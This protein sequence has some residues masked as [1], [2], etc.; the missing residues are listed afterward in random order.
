MHRGASGEEVNSRSR[1][2]PMKRRH[3]GWATATEATRFGAARVRH[4]A[5][6]VKAT[7]IKR[8]EAVR[9][10]GWKAGAVTMPFCFAFYHIHWIVYC[11]PFMMTTEMTLLNFFFLGKSPHFF[12]AIAWSILLYQLDANHGATWFKS[13]RYWYINTIGA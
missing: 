9:V 12:C 4:E 1:P 2:E 8:R 7:W 6:V 13:L 3:V 10:G 5:K 11:T